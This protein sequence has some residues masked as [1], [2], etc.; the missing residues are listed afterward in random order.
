MVLNPGSSSAWP[1][2]HSLPGRRHPMVRPATNAPPPPSCVGPNSA[3]LL[4]RRP[5]GRLR[6]LW[7]SAPAPPRASVLHQSSFQ[8]L[9][10]R[11]NYRSQMSQLTVT[12]PQIQASTTEAES[13]IPRGHAIATP[14]PLS[15]THG[16]NELAS[17]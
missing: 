12:Q 6:Q 8:N 15:N 9:R 7:G 1:L 10:L 16:L 3:S 11:F 14:S 13:V 17:R 2:R 4:H 5:R